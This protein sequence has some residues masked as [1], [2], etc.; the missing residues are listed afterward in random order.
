MIKQ[1][2]EFALEYPKKTRSLKKDGEWDVEIKF[3]RSLRRLAGIKLPNDISSKYVI[4]PSI[5]GENK[6]GRI[7][8]P[9]EIEKSDPT[10]WPGSK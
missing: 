7:I 3:R 5:S 10:L 9:D 2:R 6:W 1:L 4:Y 8:S